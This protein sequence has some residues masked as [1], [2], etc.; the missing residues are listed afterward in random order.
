MSHKVGAHPGAIAGGRATC[1]TEYSS[2][3]NAFE[4]VD[5]RE[6]W[7]LRRSATCASPYFWI[8]FKVDKSK[9]NDIFISAIAPETPRLQDKLAFNAVMYGPGLGELSAEDLASLPPGLQSTGDG[10][11]GGMRL[12]SPVNHSTCY[13]VRNQV[14]KRFA[15]MIGGRCMEDLE[16]PPDYKNPMLAGQRYRSWWL[17]S[18]DLFAP[19]DGYYYVASWLTDRKT[20]GVVSGKYELTI[21]PHVWYGYASG[22][23]Q[24]LSEAQGTTCQ[25]SENSF[26]YL[27][28]NLKLVGGPDPEALEAQLPFTQCAAAGPQDAPVDGGCTASEKRDA[29]SIGSPI[30]W[31]GVWKLPAGEY[32][33]A[34]LA[35][36]KNGEKN[37]PFYPDGVIDVFVKQSAGLDEAEKMAE[38]AMSASATRTVDAGGEIKID[39]AMKQTLVFVSPTNETLQS[40]Y[41]LSIPKG[42]TLTIFTQH[43]PTEFMATFLECTAG[44]CLGATSR[45]HFAYPSREYDVSAPAVAQGEGEAG[46]DSGS[47]FESTSASG[48]APSPRDH[49]HDHDHDRDHDHD[50]DHAPAPAM[51]QPP[52]EAI[53]SPVPPAESDLDSIQ[54]L[55]NMAT[56]EPTGAPSAAVPSK[57]SCAQMTSST[58]SLIHLGAA[59]FVSVLRL[60]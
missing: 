27:E 15:L 50:H 22:D 29:I 40:A 31:S 26:A 19:S 60:C 43:L 55:G 45:F 51:T 41:S 17:Y 7:Y 3:Q 12:Y 34:F 23:I 49:D 58:G 9:G 37:E 36:Y 11:A 24:S 38:T 14:M 4:V 8:K 53:L 44:E 25:C 57:T 1:G 46:S 42:S 47:T 16:L 21:G 30:E 39:V 54:A 48:A 13:F 33:W 10:N 2:P 18:E 35:Q 28:Q 32:R 52:T 59:L 5:V 6:A 20:G 56:R